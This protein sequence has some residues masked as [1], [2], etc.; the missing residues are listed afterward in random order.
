M[1]DKVVGSFDEAV[2]DIR[3]GARIHCGGFA[4]PFNTPSHL[5][6][7]LARTGADGLT[8]AS[9][10]AGTGQENAQVLR[11]QLASIVEWPMDYWDVG[12]LSELGRIKRLITTFP[13]ATGHARKWP[14][15]AALE[16]GEVELELTGQGS[17]AERIRCARAG[18]AGFY[19][20]VGPGTAV[21]EGKEIRDF[22]GVPHVLERAL[23]ADFAIIRAWRADRYGNLVFRGARTF[24]ETMAGA[25]TVTIAE[26]DEVV[27][28][29]DLAPDAIHT[30]GVYVQR[31]VRR[32]DTPPQSWEQP[33]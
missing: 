17:L 28:L 32:P 21:A 26:V 1:I 27:P 22:D 12:L 5:I 10:S 31:V 11:E 9:T 30:P 4:S 15:E 3:P 23:H 2:A 24:N 6:A 16:R 25:A 29:G 18:I 13:V 33:C 7:A 19:T 8:V 14:F 20:P